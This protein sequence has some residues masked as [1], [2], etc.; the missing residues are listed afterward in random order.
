MRSVTE[1]GREARDDRDDTTHVDDVPQREELGNRVSL[2]QC[3]ELQRLGEG[4]ER[5]VDE[6]EHGDPREGRA[7]VACAPVAV[8]H[9]DRR[10][11]EAHDHQNGRRELGDQVRHDRR[12][13]VDR[14]DLGH[15]HARPG[16]RL[17]RRV[18]ELQIRRQRRCLSA[19]LAS[20]RL[21]QV[22]LVV[23][24]VIAVVQHVILVA[25]L[26][27]LFAAVVLALRRGPL[28]DRERTHVLFDIIVL[29]ER[30]RDLLDRCRVLVLRARCW[31]LCLAVVGERALRQWSLR[32]LRLGEGRRRSRGVAVVVV[33]AVEDALRGFLV[34]EGIVEQGELAVV[35]IGEGLG[36]VEADE[37]GCELFNEQ[38]GH[39]VEGLS[40]GA[41]GDLDREGPDV[42]EGPDVGEVG[43]GFVRTEKVQGCGVAARS[44]HRGGR[45]VEV[46]DDVDECGC[47]FLFARDE[48]VEWRHA[49][50]LVAAAGALPRLRLGFVQQLLHAPEE[51]RH[52]LA[53]PERGR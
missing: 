33:E 38:V 44:L 4:D 31:S 9:H 16:Q 35:Q 40:V 21:V 14:V 32:R 29:V 36:G 12:R 46:G 42:T 25:G 26:V 15:D 30:G 23:V 18:R 27:L 11:V 2:R 47:E 3:D 53:S 49:G 22:V 34:L 45:G 51:R 19:P 24:V 41:V 52:R 7:D 20:N 50:V 37:L 39:A 6:R 1:A 28:F 10:R 5:G 48:H 13:R 43:V 8:V 17:P